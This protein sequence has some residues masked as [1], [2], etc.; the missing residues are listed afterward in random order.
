MNIISNKHFKN[1]L[2]TRTEK[3]NIKEYE[4]YDKKLDNIIYVFGLLSILLAI[5]LFICKTVFDFDL[6]KYTMP[7][8]LH[9][10]TGYY[11]PGCGG[12]RALAYFFSGHLLK[13]V[14]YDPFVPYILITGGWFMISQSIHRLIKSSHQ[15]FRPMTIRPVYIYVGVAILLIQCLVKN[16][17]LLLFGFQMI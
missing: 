16:L 4:P 3:N 12:T 14:Y 13:S 9:L 2:H 6:R 8:M 1:N 7:C 10:L 17:A 11:C 15:H 5:V